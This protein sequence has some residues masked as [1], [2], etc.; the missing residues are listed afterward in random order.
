MSNRQPI[1]S[2]TCEQC[3]V[4]AFMVNFLSDVPSDDLSD[5]LFISGWRDNELSGGMICNLC[6]EEL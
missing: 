5:F 1:T 2:V 4:E 6:Q 3:G